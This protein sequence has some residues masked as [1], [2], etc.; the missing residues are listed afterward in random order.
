M[1]WTCLVKRVEKPAGANSHGC[2]FAPVEKTRGISSV[3]T[4]AKR[5]LEAYVKSFTKIC[6]SVVFCH[7][8]LVF[9]PSTV[10]CL[11]SACSP[12]NVLPADWLGHVSGIEAHHTPP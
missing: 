12:S 8:W 5:L 4:F 3:F 1:A 9:A 7:S 6:L 2:K 10:Y 11:P